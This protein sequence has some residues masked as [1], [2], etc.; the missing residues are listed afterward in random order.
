[1]TRI[2]NPSIRK[3]TQGLFINLSEVLLFS[4]FYGMELALSGRKGLSLYGTQKA[5]E[6]AM[7]A[8]FEINQRSYK[9]TVKH[10]RDTGFIRLGKEGRAEITK[11]GLERLRYKLPLY[12]AQRPWDG[13]L[14]LISY[15]ISV[16]KNKDRNQLRNFLKQI[17]C[18]MLQKS[19]WLTPYNPSTLIK[20]FVEE[21]GI[22]GMVLV[23]RLGQDG[24]I[25]GYTASEIVR[26]IYKLEDLEKRYK[27]FFEKYKN[28]KREDVVVWQVANEFLAILKDDP[29]LPW[30]LLPNEWIGKQ[31]YK[32]YCYLTS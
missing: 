12:Q 17:G 20:S 9:R 13:A 8:L 23:S 26:K 1:M 10:L 3:K 28:K 31:A 21:K 11:L 32:V 2:S 16:D 4:L 27:Q 29:Q 7:E 24:T 25:G 18:G 30:E 6:K 5:G 15:D 22:A 14:Y 19:I